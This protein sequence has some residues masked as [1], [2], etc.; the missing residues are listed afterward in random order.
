MSSNNSMR[1]FNRQLKKCG[2]KGIQ[3]VSAPRNKTNIPQSS[4]SESSEGSSSQSE[5]SEEEPQGKDLADH[6][7]IDE[8]QAMGT[9]G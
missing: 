3:V 5:S 7:E 4:E 1:N 2:S 6:A 8:M 9:A